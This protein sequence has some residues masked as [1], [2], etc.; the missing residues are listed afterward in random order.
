MQHFPAFPVEPVDT[1]G[2]GDVF[3]GAYAACLAW[4]Y[5]TRAAI[6]V[7]TATAAFKATQPGGRKGIPDLATVKRF[8]EEQG[9]HERT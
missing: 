5:E 4:G 8:L 9:Y 7:A 2:C 6:A 1:T 3:H